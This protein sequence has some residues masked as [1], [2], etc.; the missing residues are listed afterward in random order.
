M[1]NVFQ[2]NETF[3]DNQKLFEK[4]KIENDVFCCT[5]D[6]KFSDSLYCVK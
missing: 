2:S 1:E 6:S 4:S 5:E 3:L